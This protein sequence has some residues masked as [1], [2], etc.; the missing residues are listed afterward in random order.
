[1]ETYH[2]LFRLLALSQ[3]LFI[4]VYLLLNQ[5]H[6]MGRLL[7]LT[8]FS[9]GCY[10]IAPISYGVWGLHSVVAIFA[11]GIPA[12][13]WLLGRFFFY[14]DRNIPPWFWLV[15]LTYFGLWVPDWQSAQLALGADASRALFDL[16]P[17][18]LKLGLVVHVIYMALEGRANDLVNPRY[19]LRV[20]VAAGGGSLA[21]IVILVELWAAGEVPMVVEVVGS[22]LLFAVCLGSNLYLFSLRDDLPLVLAK[23]LPKFKPPQTASAQKPSDNQAHIAQIRSAMAQ[24][25][26]YANHGATIGD[27]AQLLAIA[28]H[29]LRPMIN[30]ELGYRNFNQFLNEYRIE[31]ASQRLISEPKL[32]IISIALDIGF[33]SLSSFNKAFK[34]K[35]Q[36]TPSE[37]RAPRA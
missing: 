36:K 4:C 32:P 22:M 12:I 28:E 1:M 26:F 33:K 13:L 30:Q 8:L 31:E 15:S 20:P 34:D 6:A 25:R 17:Q 37:Y 7:A 9:F 18:L 21:A 23:P 3:V 24:D 2:H 19:K 5:R 16:L 14:D 27:L 11:N 10:L 29:K 35:H